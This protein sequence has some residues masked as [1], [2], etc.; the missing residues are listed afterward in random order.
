PFEEL[1]FVC[2]LH[3]PDFIFSAITSVP[4][5]TEIQDYVLKLGKAFPE[6]N[7][8]LTGYQ[9][10]GQGLDLEENTRIIPNVRQLMEIASGG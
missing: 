2:D 4:G 5:V 1:K 8:L 9:V 10:I 7:I 6:T 3:K